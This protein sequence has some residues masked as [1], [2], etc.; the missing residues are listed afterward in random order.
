MLETGKITVRHKIANVLTRGNIDFF[1][2]FEPNAADSAKKQ[3]VITDD[4][5]PVVEACIDEALRNINAF[6]AQEGEI[7]CKDVT[8]KVNNFL[9]YSAQVEQY[10]KEQLLS[11]YSDQS[12]D[13][14]RILISLRVEK[15][16][17]ESPLAS[18]ESC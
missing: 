12:I 5:W 7:L 16:Y 2:T 9:E 10:E 18:V 17:K 13:F 3:D 14:E 8:E 4:N 15:V 1:V 11:K 6:R